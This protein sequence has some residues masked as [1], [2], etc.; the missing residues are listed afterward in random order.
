MDFVYNYNDYFGNEEVKKEY[1]EF[2]FNFAGIALDKDKA[3]EF[4]SNNDF[5]FNEDVVK[6]LMKYIK[7]YVPLNACASFNSK[8]DSNFYIGISDTGYLKGIPYYGEFPIKVMKDNIYKILSENIKHITLKNID[9]NKIV[10]IN[11]YKINNPE[12]PKEVMNPKFLKYLKK[13]KIQVEL[14]K[15]YNDKYLE[16]RKCYD[17]INQKLFLLINNLDSRLILINYIKSIDPTC[18]VIELLNGDYKEVYKK[19]QEVLILKEDIKSPYYWITRWKDMMNVRMKKDKLIPLKALSNT[20]TNLIMNV[21]EMIPWW[22]HNK[23]EMNLYVIHIEFNT[24]KFEMKVSED[25]LFTYLD[26]GKKKWIKCCRIMLNGGPAC[27]P[28]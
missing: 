9:F 2:T 26:Y 16:K 22:M 13:K 21:G 10:K 4:C 19:H 23:K 8:I 7:Y 6:N 18:S 1:K 17:F 11:I 27:V 28:I 24:S 15:E 20:P 5:E 12:K 3:E 14:M 25:T